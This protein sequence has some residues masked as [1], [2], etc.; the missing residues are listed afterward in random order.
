MARYQVSYNDVPA[1]VKAL[2]NMNPEVTKVTSINGDPAS[3]FGRFNDVALTFV[4]NA[5]KISEGAKIA[6]RIPE[7]KQTFFVSKNYQLVK[8]NDVADTIIKTIEDG[9][10]YS[11]KAVYAQFNPGR[12]QFLFDYDNQIKVDVGQ[13][14][15]TPFEQA[16]RN[17]SILDYAVPNNPE[18][19]GER[20]TSSIY[21]DV[22]F[23]GRTGIILYP[24]WIRVICSNLMISLKRL[25]K[26]DTI[27]HLGDKILETINMELDTAMETVTGEYKKVVEFAVFMSWVEKFYG[28]KAVQYVTDLDF[29]EEVQKKFKLYYALQ[30]ATL[31]N[32]GINGTKISGYGLGPKSTMA[33]RQ[34]ARMGS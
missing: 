12:I 26:T 29:K 33:L 4:S 20:M 28:K 34:V 18:K 22:G 10:G 1:F 30:I 31:L 21:A 7:K 3:D 15:L 11:P 27:K 23:N 2:T 19:G 8:Y 14:D 13:L 25:V 6:V 32:R 16:I 17:T 9:Y 5:S 24:A